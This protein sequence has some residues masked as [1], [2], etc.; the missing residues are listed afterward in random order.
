MA[1][2]LSITAIVISLAGLVFNIYQFI[3]ARKLKA[4]EKSNELLN[5]VL[6]LRK[7]SQEIR[8]KV[9]NTDHVP[10]I[11]H[12]LDPLDSAIEKDFMGVLAQE[13]PKMS[14]LLQLDQRI[15]KVHTEFELLSR[16]VDAMRELNEEVKALH[17]HHTRMQ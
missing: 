16:Q 12:L 1:L 5:R 10:D 7:L 9:S 2:T 17:Q 13:S 4:R 3:S 14:D 11:D 6:L 8:H 15:S